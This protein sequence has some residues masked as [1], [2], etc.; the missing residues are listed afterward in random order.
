MPKEIERKWLVNKLPKINLKEGINILQGY[1]V[2]NG[3][4]EVRV[5]KAGKKYSLTVKKGE[6]ISRDEVD[7]HIPSSTFKQLWELT[8]GT[9][10]SK[11]R[12][13]IEHEGVDLVLDIYSGNLLK[14]HIVEAEFSSVEEA[15]KFVPPDWVGKELT[16]DKRYSNRV[17]A[18]KGIPS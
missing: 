9:R 14:L 16:G 4:S 8:D 13:V 5:R 12:Y 15:L 3:S 11:V 17:L 18:E 10:I 1:L 7:I 6:G 2:S